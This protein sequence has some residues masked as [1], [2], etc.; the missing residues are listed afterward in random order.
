MACVTSCSQN[1]I[2]IVD[3]LSAYNASI[4]EELCVNC[5]ACQRVCQVCN[6]VEVQAPV[7]W[8]Q[9]WALENSIRATSSSGGY[10][11][12]IAKAFIRGGEYAAAILLKENFALK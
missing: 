2:K 5:G 6:P 9:G 10:A 4:D 12:S 8:K 11:T 7:Y 3:S 1:A